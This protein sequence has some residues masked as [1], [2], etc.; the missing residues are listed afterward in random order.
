VV[1]FFYFGALIDDTLPLHRMRA[2]Y[3]QKKEGKSFMP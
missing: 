2:G 3:V 1:S